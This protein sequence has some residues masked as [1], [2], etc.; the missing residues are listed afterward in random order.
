MYVAVADDELS[1]IAALI[2][3]SFRG[4]GSPT[5]WST[6]TPFLAGDRTTAMA[7]RAD[8]L[9]RPSAT[10]LKWVDADSDRSSGCVWLES[11]GSGAWYLGSLAIE[12]AKQNGG[13][14][15]IMLSAAEQWI[16]E[17]GG[18]RVRMTVVNVREA[19]I[20]WYIRRGY[21][22]TGESEP[23]PYE[24]HSGSAPLGNDYRLVVLEKEL[25]PS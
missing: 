19:L 17:R 23:F 13:L 16:A 20:A 7:L 6:A 8:L 12:P 5:E 1:A 24:E 9:A 4:S 11:L 18:R 15:R 2:N 10:L 21:H 22:P 14:G 25:K 3:R